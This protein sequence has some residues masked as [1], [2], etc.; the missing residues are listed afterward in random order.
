V[1]RRRR[2]RGVTAPQPPRAGTLDYHVARVLLLLSALSGTADG[3]TKIAK[4]DFLLRYPNMLERVLAER[5]RGW[6]PGTSPTVE[7]RSAIESAMVR[8]KYG[9]WDDRYYP[10]LGTLLGTG[11]VETRPGRGRI[12]VTVTSAGRALADALARTPEWATVSARCELIADVLGDEN[13]TFL[14]DLIYRVLPDAVDRPHR[15]PI[16]PGPRP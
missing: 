13:G 11:L 12:A 15:E 14:K 7:E 1:D 16:G 9:P 8:Y 10:I 5:G 2:T 3:L 6:E 4:L